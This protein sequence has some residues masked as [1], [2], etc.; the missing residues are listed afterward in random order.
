MRAV[1]FDLTALSQE[2]EEGQRTLAATKGA[3]RLTEIR[4]AF[5]DC[6]VLAADQPTRR[7]RGSTVEPTA[8]A[9]CHIDDPEWNRL[10]V[11]KTLF[12][13]LWE[14]FG[15]L[16]PETAEKFHL[17]SGPHWPV[18]VDAKDEFCPLPD[19]TA[20]HMAE[21]HLQWVF[22]DRDVSDLQD[23]ADTAREGSHGNPAIEPNNLFLTCKACR[24]RLS[25][26]PGSFANSQRK[27]T[28]RCR[29]CAGANYD[30]LY[31]RIVE[32]TPNPSQEPH[33]SPV[34]RASPDVCM[35][36]R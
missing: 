25:N 28:V 19:E 10:N 24:I 21:T 8:T 36:V 6:Y 20:Q 16:K 31:P 35:Y 15:A 3:D 18:P 34:P 29:S 17:R 27:T 13:V 1:D 23:A 32:G 33:A 9:N 14:C 11:S 7:L 5:K 12:G 26:C 30:A 2:R 22:C 4:H